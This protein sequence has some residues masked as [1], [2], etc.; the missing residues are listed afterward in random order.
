MDQDEAP[1]LPF[2]ARSWRL[3]RSFT[4][5]VSN[6]AG[7]VWRSDRDFERALDNLSKFEDALKNRIHRRGSNWRWFARS[8]MLWSAALEV[9]FLSYAIVMTHSG[10]LEW[11]RRALIVLPVFLLPA[12]ATL[13]YKVLARYYRMRERQ[14]KQAL[15]DVQQKMKRRLDEV[16]DKSNF[17]RTLEVIQK[18]DNDPVVKAAAATVLGSKLGLKTD[19]PPEIQ[20]HLT[21]TKSASTPDRSPSSGLRNRRSSG[22]HP[23]SSLNPEVSSQGVPRSAQGRVSQEGNSPRP[24][25]GAPG[26]GFEGFG[27][28]TAGNWQP[29]QHQTGGVVGMLERVAQMLVGEDPTQ[30]YALICERCRQHNGLAKKEDME[31][32]MYHCRFCSHLN[33]TKDDNIERKCRCYFCSEI[34]RRTGVELEAPSPDTGT[35][36]KGEKSSAGGLERI[37]DDGEQPTEEKN[38]DGKRVTVG[39][40]GDLTELRGSKTSAL[41]QSGKGSS[42]GAIDEGW[43]DVK[44]RTNQPVTS[45]VSLR[46]CSEELQHGKAKG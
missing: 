42:K 6:I 29:G 46:L 20:A 44:S 16:K 39:G 23:P 45:N 3:A 8:I 43:E 2:F 28:A 21:P 27:P 7:M 24:S 26:P 12:C 19:L 38:V 5:G 4:G 34:R 10:G 36:R 40:R 18:Y 41:S 15:A 35:P 17:Y 25:Y 33:G 22:A 1:S 11:Q 31:V 13:L 37:G 30:C 32:L 9:V 14:D